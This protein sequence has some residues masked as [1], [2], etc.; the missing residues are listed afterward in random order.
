MA[1]QPAGSSEILE[2]V[3]LLVIDMQD[4]FLAPIA[5]SDQLLVRCGL[6]VSAARA[7]G[8]KVIFTEQ[9]PDKLGPTNEKLLALAPGARVFPKDAFSALQ[10]PGIHEHLK[11]LGVYH[12]IVVGIETPVCIY[13]TALH[14]RDSDLDVTVLSDCVGGRR[15][16]DCRVAIDSIV[17][18][19]CHVLPG[20]TVFY[21]MLGSGSHRHFRQFTDLVKQFG[22]M[23]RLETPKT[24][25]RSKPAESQEGEK[26]RPP[27]RRGRGRKREDA[28]APVEKTPAPEK[29]TVKT[30]LRVSASSES[31]PPPA[32]EAAGS[33]IMKP[34]KR[35]RSG[36]SRRVGTA[37][38][39][40][41]PKTDAD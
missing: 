3:A 30:P 5:N 38:K 25:A 22:A 32:D 7:L 15:A 28:E 13:Q 23:E 29:K 20:E 40:P 21:S 41:A 31:P 6:A 4:S 18:T 27:R 8:I 37:R 39:K 35:R 34:A 17:R 16:D 24:I 1:S 2:A 11:R 9:V 26:K 36:R 10:A 33:E 19:D 12:L 14:A